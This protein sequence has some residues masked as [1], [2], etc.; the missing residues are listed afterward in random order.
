MI[1]RNQAQIKTLEKII[2][3]LQNQI[4]TYLNESYY[5]RTNKEENLVP[6]YFVIFFFHVIA[7]IGLVADNCK[8]MLQL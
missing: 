7:G 1:I 4:S 2:Y 5:Y 8:H 3:L 6:T